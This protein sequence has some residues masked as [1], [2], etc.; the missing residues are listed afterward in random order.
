VDLPRPRD[1]YSAEFL[2]LAKKIEK[3]VRS[4]FDQYLKKYPSIETAFE[5][6]LRNN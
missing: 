6:I 5:K 1:P 4:E 3:D 2:A